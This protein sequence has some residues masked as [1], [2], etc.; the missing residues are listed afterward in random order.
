MHTRM[1]KGGKVGIVLKAKPT[2]GQGTRFMSPAEG[3]VFVKGQTSESSV[4]SA[5]SR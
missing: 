5:V 2:E 4:E 1:K 3:T